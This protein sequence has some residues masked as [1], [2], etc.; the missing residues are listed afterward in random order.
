VLKLHFK[1]EDEADSLVA[2][3]L[4]VVDQDDKIKYY[5][6]DQHAFV[7]NAASYP[8]SVLK[9]L[10]VLLS[11]RLATGVYTY[12]FGIDL[13]NNGVLNVDA[14]HVADVTV[15]VADF[16]TAPLVPDK[17]INAIDENGHDIQFPV[18]EVIVLAN[19][20]VS[21]AVII[22]LVEKL[23]GNVVGQI[24]SLSMYQA[25]FQTTT[26]A[27]LDKI[28]SQLLSNP[29]VSFASYNKIAE[30]AALSYPPKT[31]P[32]ILSGCAFSDIDY[33]PALSVM[34]NLD[35]IIS[36]S[37]VSVAVIE[38]SADKKHSELSHIKPFVN[39]TK[40]EDPF[41]N[42]N[43]ALLKQLCTKP[44]LV[45]MFNDSR[46]PISECPQFLIDHGSQ[47]LGVIA[48]A[49]NG[50]GVNGL[51]SQI[52]G[53]KLQVSLGYNMSILGFYKAV[54]RAKVQL[55]ASI[56]NYSGFLSLTAQE[57]QKY[58]NILKNKFSDILFIVSAPNESVELKSK[59][60]WPGD[61]DL[62]NIVTVGGTALCQPTK[63]WKSSAYGQG[64]D[65]AAPADRVPVINTTFS[66]NGIKS[67]NSF[68]TPM[69]TSLAAIIKSIDPS[70]T[71]SEISNYLLYGP[72]IPL[73]ENLG[74]NRLSFYDILVK[75]IIAKYPNLNNGFGE[76]FAF[77]W[78]SQLVNVYYGKESYTIKKVDFGSV[79]GYNLTV[80][81]IDAQGK[82][83][84][85]IGDIA[86][87]GSKAETIFNSGNN[88]RLGTAMKGKML[89]SKVFEQTVCS[90]SAATVNISKCTIVMRPS[91]GKSWMHPG[92][93]PSYEK[94]YWL[95]SKGKMDAHLRCIK[96]NANSIEEFQTTGSFDFNEIIAVSPDSNSKYSR[97]IE[98][99]C[100][101]GINLYPTLNP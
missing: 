11:E 95:L 23:G 67:G 54:E 29:N 38:V 76:G 89:V 37:P 93:D 88:Y 36:L 79:N 3:Q 72:E 61:T 31:D 6:I 15:Y 53:T 49:D 18:N 26:K 84:I 40:I 7:D 27:E 77:A 22:G 69:V 20:G 5:D 96:G 33:I 57:K 39:L 75:A 59:N 70:L 52:L 82:F 32:D 2:G 55:K 10:T 35:Y 44:S 78:R 21:G 25:R 73:S 98:Q 74:S 41:P 34:E 62:N 45:K 1:E 97:Y 94:V 58:T 19:E 46:I 83:R 17:I 9:N 12:Y 30:Q 91:L 71:P 87:A 13:V 66:S 81:A 56:V 68:A 85:D 48:A 42:I 43:D 100:G 14:E 63:R 60:M 50:Q 90:D 8:L 4:I 80:P 51:A 64:I 47:V 86:K 65:I 24:P 28:L 92:G 99:N 101:G 16:Y